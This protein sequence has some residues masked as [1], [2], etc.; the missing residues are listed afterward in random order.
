MDIRYLT[1]SKQQL[2]LSCALEVDSL[3]A[4]AIPLQSLCYAYVKEVFISLFS[5]VFSQLEA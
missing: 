4:E 2:V 1:L 3:A 5:V